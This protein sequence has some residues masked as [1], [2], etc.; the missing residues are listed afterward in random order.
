MLLRDSGTRRRAEV[1]PL[2]PPETLALPLPDAEEDGLDDDGGLACTPARV[3]RR[4][5]TGGIGLLVGW[6]MVR[7]IMMEYL[8]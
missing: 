3:W 6:M 4:G 5:F 7:L 2:L 8:M 1:A